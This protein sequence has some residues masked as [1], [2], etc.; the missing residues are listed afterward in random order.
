MITGRVPALFVLLG[1]LA[2][3][4]ADALR[5]GPWSALG[6]ALGVVVL[7]ALVDWIV[8]APAGEVGR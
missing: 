7:L 1:V 5:L 3:A 2:V 6:S 8:A 4:F